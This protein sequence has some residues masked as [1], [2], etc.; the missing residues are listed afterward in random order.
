MKNIQEFLKGLFSKIDPNDSL[1]IITVKFLLFIA[2]LTVST[3][4]I[5]HLTSFDVTENRNQSPFANVDRFSPEADSLRREYKA[6][7]D[8][9]NECALS[10][11]S[12]GTYTPYDYI[13]DMYTVLRLDEMY[14][15]LTFGSFSF[16]FSSNLRISHPDFFDTRNPACEDFGNAAT[17]IERAH[18]KGHPEPEP[19]TWESFLQWLWDWYFNALPLA[20]LMCCILGWQKRISFSVRSPFS[21]LLYCILWPI[22]FFVRARRRII[23]IDAEARIRMSKESLFSKLS[24]KERQFL[25]TYNSF[26][27][28]RNNSREK[29]LQEKSEAKHEV[30]RI[31]LS[32]SRLSP[33]YVLAFGVVVL[34]RVFS[35]AEEKSP[36]LIVQDCLQSGVEISLIQE[37]PP[38]ISQQLKHEKCGWLWNVNPDENLGDVRLCQEKKIVPRVRMS[39]LKGYI[40][41]I[42]KV[43]L[44]VN[45]CVINKCIHQIF[46]CNEKK[47]YGD[48]VCVRHSAYFG[49]NHK[50]PK[51]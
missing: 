51:L 18:T 22:N 16:D 15:N 3:G 43:P 17:E 12:N 25:E 46:K 45:A 28:S 38:D 39:L 30:A 37:S 14:R 35:F 23:D 20:F 13:Y 4:F 32:L 26:A 19:F 42:L 1:R 44:G 7:C 33:R 6:L 50:H 5:A 27:S 40:Q 29:W 34:F 9:I 31:L 10:S 8:D 48:V 49:A 24:E 2:I 21:A 36:T 11:L 41:E 47:L